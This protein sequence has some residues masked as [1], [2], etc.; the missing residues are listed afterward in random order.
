MPIKFLKADWN[1]KLEEMEGAAKISTL[2]YGNA[3]GKKM[4]WVWFLRVY[5]LI[6]C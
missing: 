2:C 6:G 1:V 5:G 3:A 4:G